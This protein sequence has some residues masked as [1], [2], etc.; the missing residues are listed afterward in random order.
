MRF[1][2]RKLISRRMYY[3]DCL[4]TSN[5]K[6]IDFRSQLRKENNKQRRSASFSPRSISGQKIQRVEIF[7]KDK[8]DK[9]RKRNKNLIILNNENKRRFNQLSI[10][11]L[12]CQSKLKEQGRANNRRYRDCIVN[13]FQKERHKYRKQKKKSIENVLFSHKSILYLRESIQ[14][15]IPT[16]VHAIRNRSIT[17][18]IQKSI[19]NQDSSLRK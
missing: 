13:H 17:N 19:L 16:S 15:L 3:R 11:F 14:Y 4:I 1:Y 8:R 12:L 7:Y 2:R 18:S 10:N 9:L 6:I 5:K